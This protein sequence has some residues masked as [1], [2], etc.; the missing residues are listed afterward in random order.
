MNRDLLVDLARRRK[1]E[2][3]LHPVAEQLERGSSKAGEGLADEPEEYSAVGRHRAQRI[4]TFAKARASIPTRDQLPLLPFTT[5]PHLDERLRV[6]FADFPAA[7]VPASGSRARPTPETEDTITVHEWATIRG[8]H[9]EFSVRAS[10]SFH[11]R[12]VYSWVEIENGSSPEASWYAQVLLVLEVAH[13]DQPQRLA[14]VNY[15]TRLPRAEAALH[16]ATDQVFAWYSCHPDI[17][18]LD[19]VLRVVSF[20]PSFCAARSRHGPVFVLVDRVHAG[21]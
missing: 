5:P 16:A 17:I 8:A 7:R 10:E 4:V 3:F 11:G 14:L 20:V 21:A 9:G 1:I 12:P 2:L 18:S 6:Y 15:L 19:N 13:G